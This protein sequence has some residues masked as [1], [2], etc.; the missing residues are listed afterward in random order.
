MEQKQITA[1]I[2]AAGCST[3]MEQFKPLLKIGDKTVI[4]RSIFMFHDA[5]IHDIRVVVGH[6]QDQM[7]SILENA[8]VRILINR[9][10]SPE[11]FSS[12]IA[13]LDSLEPE[14]QSIVLLPGD[15]PLVRPWTANYLLKQH[16]KKPETILVPSFQGK[17][18][19]PV[20]IPAELADTIRKWEGEDGL[21]GALNSLKDKLLAIPV[22]DANILFDMDTP[23]DYKEAQ[24]R[25]LG[26]TVPT[27]DECQSILRDLFCVNENI[28]GH[29]ITVAGVARSICDALISSGCQMD[30]EVIT[31]SALLHDMAKGDAHHEQKAAGVLAEMGFPEI[32]SIVACH[33]DIECSYHA[34]VSPAEILYLADKLVN[35]NTIV[36]ITERFQSALEKFGNDPEVKQKIEKRKEHARI[37]MNKVERAVGHTKIKVR[38]FRNRP[39]DIDFGEKTDYSELE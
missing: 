31:A 2:L 4:E 37:I 24:E 33:T 5:G 17:R 16:L 26:Y 6:F 3:R 27:R 10:G 13:A 32:A 28:V 21:K 30:K 1:V 36:S 23:E 34:P 35:G 38:E 11:M 12:V 9:T 25:W 14:V 8:G 15:I 20:I 7:E 19:H 18:G 22:A 29:S 39:I